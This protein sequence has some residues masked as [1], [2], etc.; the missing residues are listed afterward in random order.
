MGAGLNV[1][2]KVKHFWSAVLAAVILAG[3][4]S[5]IAN[6]KKNGSG[7]AEDIAAVC[8][9]AANLCTT[10]CKLNSSPQG[11]YDSCADNYG[12]CVGDISRVKRPEITKK[13]AVPSVAQ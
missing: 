6:A 2:K 8:L 9:A 10:T 11:C 7:S 4:F 5:N 12:A 1:E 13:K 3:L